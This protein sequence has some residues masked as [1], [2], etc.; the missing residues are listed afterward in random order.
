[1]LQIPNLQTRVHPT[2]PSQSKLLRSG[3]IMVKS[4]ITLTK[5]EKFM[6]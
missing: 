6:I 4:R 1:M 2:L 5:A 3:K